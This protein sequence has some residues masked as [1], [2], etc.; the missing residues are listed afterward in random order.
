MPRGL[1]DYYNPDTLVSQRL[2]NVE[3]VVSAV[4]G[5]A[6]LDNRGRTFYYDHFGEGVN[7]WS[8]AKGGDAVEAAA[9]TAKAEIEPAS[10]KINS[11]T[12]TG[13]GSAIVAKSWLI[14][15]IKSGGL[16]FSYIHNTIAPELTVDLI[17]DNGTLRLFGRLVFD[18]DAGTVSILDNITLRTVYT[19]PGGATPFKW[20][21]VKIVCDFETPA[22]VRFLAGLEQTDISAYSIA[23]NPSQ[24]AGTL[25]VRFT[26]DALDD[27]ENTAFIG[28]VTL[29]IDEP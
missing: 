21:T 23:T 19:L 15:D 14:N 4:Q 10:L 7:G 28:H 1:P 24:V 3:E 12:D 6:N 8:K 18:H 25:E 20:L 2:A 11:G 29:T 5:I 9:S 17:Y 26:A 27:N 22:Y 16:E 13:N